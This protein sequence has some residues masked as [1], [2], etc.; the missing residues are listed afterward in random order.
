MTSPAVRVVPTQSELLERFS[1]VLRRLRRERGLSQKALA[2]AANL[3]PS[4]IYY[5]E[6]ERM[7]P[8]LVTLTKLAGALSV[9]VE[10]F[11]EEQQ[12][13]VINHSTT[14]RL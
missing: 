3:H 8:R 1:S 11:V 7:K 14:T 9:P 6:S 10:V 5:L 2:Q 4:H 13:E 12:Q